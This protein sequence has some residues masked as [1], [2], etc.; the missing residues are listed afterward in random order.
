MLAEG[1]LLACLGPR[2]HNDRRSAKYPQLITP[3]SICHHHNNFSILYDPPC[4]L[5]FVFLSLSLSFLPCVLGFLCV[6]FVFL[7][8]VLFFC[9]CFVFPLCFAFYPVFW[10]FFLVLSFIPLCIILSS[11][12]FG[13]LCVFCLSSLC[14]RISS[15][16]FV[17]SLCATSHVSAMS[18]GMRCLTNPQLL[19]QPR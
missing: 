9:L 11:L 10:I 8:S 7:L 5:R 17:F 3:L 6:C 18:C 16:C 19:T 15:L 1:P 4:C 13:F 2:R 12:Y 14:F